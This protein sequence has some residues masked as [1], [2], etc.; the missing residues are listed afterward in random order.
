MSKVIILLLVFF[1]LGFTIPTKAQFLSYEDYVHLS[2]VKQEEFVIKIMELVTEIETKYIHDTKKYGFNQDRFEKFKNKMEQI[3]ILF[4]LPSAYADDVFDASEWSV[5]QNHMLK[6]QSNKNLCFYAGWIS[7]MYR[8]KEGNL[9]CMHPARVE[10]F[11]SGYPRKT[12]VMA[13]LFQECP[14]QT[15]VHCNPLIFGY[16]ETKSRS[17]FCVNTADGAQNSSYQCMKLAL[18]GPDKNERLDYL[19]KK[20]KQQKAYEAARGFIYKSCLCSNNDHLDKDFQDSVRPRLTCYSLLEMMRNV[21]YEGCKAPQTFQ[22][23]SLNIFESIHSHMKKFED[24]S[25][26]VLL[27]REYKSFIKDKLS[28]T[29]MEKEVKAVCEGV[30]ESYKCE[31]ASCKVKSED[32]KKTTSSC[33]VRIK[34]IEGKKNKAIE[35]TNLVKLPE[36]SQKGSF[37]FIGDLSGKKLTVTCPK[38]QFEEEK[39]PKLTVESPKQEPPAADKQTD[40]K[41]ILAPTTPPVTK[42]L[43][44]PVVAP[45]PTAA[46]S[47]APAPAPAGAPAVEPTPPAPTPG[48]AVEPTPPAPTP[49]APTPPVEPTPTAPAPTEA[50]PAEDSSE[51]AKQDKKPEIEL[52]KS[53]EKATASIKAQLKD[54]EG[55]TL[56]W[57]VKDTDQ[58]VEKAWEKK[59]P[60]SGIE[61]ELP[62]DGSIDKTQSPAP[63]LEFSQPRYSF[64]YTICG[65]L[66][67]DKESPVED[68]IEVPQ[69]EQKPAVLG[70]LFAPPGM[71]PPPPM[72]QSSDT[73]AMGIK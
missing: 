29:E 67:K 63:V 60:S 43:T 25:D 73:S 8:N 49:G 17:L 58:K 28:S 23:E 39:N 40:P 14:H 46:P 50:A 1:F 72:R 34:K 51:P 52:I 59:E 6:A 56:S 53:D 12:G 18:S 3:S 2:D 32:E 44:G 4:G 48:A 55:W 62:D 38:V 71:T 19:R 37:E 68:C 36:S 9:R 61:A 10:N 24:T 16:K 41:L 15:Q 66:A 70:P 64:S 5:I 22:T 54:A 47:P 11:K 69:L 20:L 27:E 42:S 45:T 26:Q 13:S 30:K 31:R 21:S 7:E 33:S 35:L 57:Y 65:K